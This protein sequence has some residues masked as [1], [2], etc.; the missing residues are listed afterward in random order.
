MI[1]KFRAWDNREKDLIYGIVPLSDG[2]FLLENVNSDKYVD[3]YPNID[4]LPP[5]EFVINQFTGL[6]DKNGKDIYAGDILQFNSPII[7]RLKEIAE[8][9]WNDKYCSFEVRGK[10]VADCLNKNLGIYIKRLKD[11]P[12]FEVIGNIYENA[13]LLEEPF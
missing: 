6:K 13:E 11:K 5:S 12:Q 3:K 9:F 1:L 7:E 2:T 4:I 10:D 8:V